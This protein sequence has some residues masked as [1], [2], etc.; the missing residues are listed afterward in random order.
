[1]LSALY[2]IEYRSSVRLSV[3]HMGGSVCQKRLEVRIMQFSP[4][5]SPIP[6]VFVGGKFHPEI[7]KG[8]LSGGVK[9]M[10][11]HE[12]SS[13]FLSLCINISKTVRDKSI[14]SY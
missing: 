13:H 7:L 3:R 14:L 11:V 1:M 5:G 9:H 2:V 8:S 6:L 10:R 12:K 4:Y